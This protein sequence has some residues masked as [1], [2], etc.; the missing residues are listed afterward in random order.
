LRQAQD[1]FEQWKPNL[2]GPVTKLHVQR[3]NGQVLE[4]VSVAGSASKFTSQTLS[5]VATDSNPANYRVETQQ[6]EMTRPGFDSNSDC[7]TQFRKVVYSGK[8]VDMNVMNE[9]KRYEIHQTLS[10]FCYN[11]IEN[12][13]IR[14]LTIH[15]DGVTREDGETEDEFKLRKVLVKRAADLQKMMEN[16]EFSQNSSMPS[17]QVP[18]TKEKLAE[19]EM[20][21]AQAVFSQITQLMSHNQ[22]PVI[23]DLNQTLTQLEA[24]LSQGV[25][26]ISNVKNGAQQENGRNH[27]VGKK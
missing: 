13:P 10:P 26:Q 6:M 9:A 25:L 27:G 20:A 5:K 3:G 22:R 18:K 24:D 8:G 16:L 15:Q 21:R 4:Q 17:G 1:N 7:T 19:E 23:C 12:C 2:N 14:I 11:L